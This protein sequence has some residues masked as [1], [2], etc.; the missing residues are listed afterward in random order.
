MLSP[1]LRAHEVT[2]VAGKQHVEEVPRKEQ[3]GHRE[4]E[5]AES[6]AQVLELSAL[7]SFHIDRAGRRG[8]LPSF[9]DCAHG[10]TSV[11]FGKRQITSGRQ[12]SALEDVRHA[13]G[14]APGRGRTNPEV[15]R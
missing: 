7:L 1:H 12:I 2:G 11:R 5:G 13:S 8:S 10:N 3:R 9:F 6:A 14:E 15:R 4:H